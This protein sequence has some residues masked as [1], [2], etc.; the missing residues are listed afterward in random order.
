[1]FENLIFKNPTLI[2]LIDKI[3]YLLGGF[4]VGLITA[5]IVTFFV[6]GVECIA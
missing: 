5:L 4:V 2:L 1:M 6:K 3:Y